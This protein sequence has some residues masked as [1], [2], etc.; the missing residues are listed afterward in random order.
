MPL[1]SGSIAYLGAARFQ[2]YWN[3]EANRATGSALTGAP[4][5]PIYGLFL[6][7]AST[8]YSGGYAAATGL[9]ASIGSYWQVTGTTATSVGHNIDGQT[10]WRLNDWVIYSG[11]VGGSQPTWQK[12]AFEDSI[13]SIIVGDM[14][15]TSLWHLT[16][17]ANKHVLFISG[18]VD[19]TV[20]HSGSKDFV[21]DYTNSR[22]GIGTASPGGPLHVYKAAASAD[23]TPM[24]LLRLEQQDEGVDMSAGHGPAITFYVGETGGSDHGGSVAVVR[25][26]QGD[27]DSAAAMSFYTAADDSAPTEKMR[28]TSAGLVGIGTATP[29]ASALLE[30]SSTTQGFLPPS[31][32]TTERNAIGSPAEGLVVYNETTNQL[33]VYDGSS[34][35]IAGGAAINNA[36][37]NELVT[38]ASTVTELDAEANLT[39]DGSTLKTLGAAIANSISNITTVAT[40]TTIAAGYNSL[41]LGPITIGA[42]VTFTIA[43]GAALKIKDISDI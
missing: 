12:M 30:L 18:T 6:T 5:G 27:A 21:Y 2:G 41:M 1:A 13:A 20:V 40:T 37:E 10:S 31:L 29:V 22:V 16:G 19:S 39:F 36:T 7:G 11:S 38:V 34:W 4:S 42:G 43:A 8:V 32:T 24:E 28:I 25:E 35:T 3:A 9:T 14:S 23:H 33:N 17:S 15:A 26:E